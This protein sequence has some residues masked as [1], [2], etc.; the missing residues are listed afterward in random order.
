MTIVF[1]A[2]E[3]LEMAEQIERNGARFY[4]QAAD[5]QMDPGQ[6]EMLLE[7]AAMEDEHEKVFADMR[8]NLPGSEGGS[9]AFDPQGEAAS[10][11][12]AMADGHVFDTKTDPTAFLESHRSITDILRKAL[13]LEKDSIVFYL[14]MKDIVPE[15]LGK[16]RIESIIREEMSHVVLL[17]RELRAHSDSGSNSRE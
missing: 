7:L 9:S 12:R 10:Y 1:N 8:A 17:D 4:R 11:L 3:I 5:G 2:D 6:R 15:R 13:D 14:G 16:D